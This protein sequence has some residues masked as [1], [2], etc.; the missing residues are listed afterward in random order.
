MGNF[1]RK[2]TPIKDLYIIEP[3]VYGDHRG[4]FYGKL[5]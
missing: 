4:F 2:E 5:F 1:I 3:K